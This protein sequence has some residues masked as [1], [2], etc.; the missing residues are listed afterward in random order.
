MYN[1]KYQRS[2]L[3]KYIN[4]YLLKKNLKMK[5]VLINI[6]KR[7]ENNQFITLRQYNSMIKF[8]EREGEFIRSNRDEIY[9]FFE[10]I[11]EVRE[12]KG[13]QYGNDLNEHFI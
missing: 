6:K 3:L 13:I 4:Q 12:R 1:S 10:P 8:I 9:R 5:N 2:L 7:L 11:I